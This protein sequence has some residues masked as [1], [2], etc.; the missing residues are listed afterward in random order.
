[1]R[2]SSSSSISSIVF[3]AGTIVTVLACSS[4]ESTPAGTAPDGGSTS[5]GGGSSS[6]DDGGS[7]SG[8]TSSGGSS[9]TPDAT[10][11]LVKNTTV[12]MQHDGEERTYVLSVPTDYQATKKYPLY[13]WLH[14]HPGSAEGAAGHRIDRGTKNEAIIAYPGALSGYWDHSAGTTDNADVTF[15]FAMIDAI[16]ASHSID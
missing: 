13:V 9:G 14:A 12:K 4:S 11:D 8:T 6:G 2:F 15:I 10:V 1:M 5:S 7:S 16:E 3:V